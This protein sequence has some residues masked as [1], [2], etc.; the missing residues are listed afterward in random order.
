MITNRHARRSDARTIPSAASGSHETPCSRILVM[1]LALVAL[2]IQTLAVQSHVH[3]SQAA[4]NVL[5]DSLI[6]GLGAT[7]TDHSSSGQHHKYPDNQD[8]SK[9][10][11]CQQLGHSGQFVASAVVLISFRCCVS[12]FFVAFSE[13]ARALSAVRHSWQ[14]RAPPQ[15]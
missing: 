8:P 6:A 12:V 2:T 14:S 4:D 13:S 3:H 7:G 1:I 5:T 15:G 10:P 11:F 9:C